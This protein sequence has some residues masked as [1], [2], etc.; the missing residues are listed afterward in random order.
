MTVKS[1]VVRFPQRANAEIEAKK[2]AKQLAEKFCRGDIAALVHWDR[3]SEVL[4]V[5]V[6][7]TVGKESAIQFLLNAI[8]LLEETE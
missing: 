1:K 8:K 4:H 2:S 3:T 5:E 7:G 6:F